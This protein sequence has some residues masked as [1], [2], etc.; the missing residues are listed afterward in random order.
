MWQ[1]GRE[2]EGKGDRRMREET[3]ERVG[4]VGSEKENGRS[5]TEGGETREYRYGRRKGREREWETEIK[6]GCTKLG[7][8]D[9]K[10]T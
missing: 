2:G 6:R 4:V 8:S 5:D 3:R 9:G 10:M 1:G 7:D